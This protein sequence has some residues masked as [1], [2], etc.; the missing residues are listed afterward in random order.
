MTGESAFRAA[1]WTLLALLLLIR[2][3]FAIRVRRAGER[4]MPDQAAIEREGR[5]MFGFRVVAFFLLIG[6]LVTYALNPPWSQRLLFPLPGWLRWFGFGLGLVSL[7]LLAW[8]QL[9]LGKQWSA[10]LQLREEHVLVTSGPYSLVRHPLYMA[11]FGLG[12][13]L[14][15][16]GANW[17]F[18]VITLASVAGLSARVPREEQMMIEQFGGQYLGYMKETGRYF[19]RMPVKGGTK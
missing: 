16:V 12:A 13:G 2:A 19:P 7:A 14:A 1:F 9:E 3:Y 18:V 6:L 15:L 8:T 10:Q 11:T 17:A 5:A 4:I